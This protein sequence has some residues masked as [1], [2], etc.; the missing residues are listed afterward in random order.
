MIRRRAARACRCGCAECTHST[1]KRMPPRQYTNP[2]I[3]EALCQVRYQHVASWDPTVP[4]RIYERVR[5]RYDGTPR[6]QPEFALNFQVGAP[7]TIAAPL[8]IAA[9]GRVQ[10][11]NASNSRILAVEPN[12]VTVSVLKPYPG[13]ESF[14]PEI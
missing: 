11:P 8:A 1:R 12:A 13:W 10:F 4:G 14:R 7:T 2:P 5:G 6:L 3:E 9:S